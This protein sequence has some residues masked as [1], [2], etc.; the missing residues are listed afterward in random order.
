M[1]SLTLNIFC[2]VTYL[3]SGGQVGDILKAVVTCDKCK[4]PILERTEE[5]AEQPQSE[6]RWPILRYNSQT[7]KEKSPLEA[8]IRSK[9]LVKEKEFVRQ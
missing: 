1:K 8:V 6:K 3:N 2:I 4:S 9:F 5:R 7:V